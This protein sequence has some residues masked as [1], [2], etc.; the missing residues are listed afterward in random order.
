MLTDLTL[1]ITGFSFAAYG[2]FIVFKPDVIARLL[3]F[4]FKDA[5]ARVEFIAMYGGLQVAL[6]VMCSAGLFYPELRQ[7]GLLLCL[8]AMGGM[9]LSRLVALLASKQK[10]N[11][12]N[13]VALLSE[14]IL[15]V[16]AVLAWIQ[17]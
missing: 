10:A 17:Q 4:A 9:A 16:L 8:L 1:A 14:I 15:V 12:C 3:G 7:G 5:N 2:L 6:G 13:Q 11:W